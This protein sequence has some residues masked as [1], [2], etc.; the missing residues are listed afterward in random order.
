MTPFASTGGSQKDHRARLLFPLLC[1]GTAPTPPAGTSPQ[2]PAFR[3]GYGPPHPPLGPDVGYGGKE[4]PAD[5][6]MGARTLV[7]ER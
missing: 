4:R 3:A 6:I 5:T 2:I 7:E 1:G